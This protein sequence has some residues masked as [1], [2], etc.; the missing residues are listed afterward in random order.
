[1]FEKEIQRF[2]FYDKYS[3]FNHDLGRRET[4][5][6][7]VDRV[8]D[9]LIEL[10]G[11]KLSEESY[12]LI[13]NEILEGR[14]SPSMRLMATAGKAARRNPLLLYNCAYAPIADI[15]AFA[16]ILWLSMSGVGVGYS[17]EKQYTN[18]LP[19]IVE[20]IPSARIDDFLIDDS[21][22]GWVV[23][24]AMAVKTWFFGGDITFDY[25]EIRLEGTPL[26]TKGGTASGPGVLIDLMNRTREIILDAQGRKLKPI[27]VF[28]IVTT[29]GNCAVSGGVRRSAQLTMFDV[30]D[31]EMMTAKKGEFW[32]T[33]PYR[34][35]ANIS[36][37]WTNVRTR[38][39]IADQLNTMF[40]NQTGEPGIVSRL[41]MNLTKPERRRRLEHGGLNPC[42]PAFATVLTPEGIRTIGE[43]D[44]G[45]VIW[46]G[47]QWTRIVNKWST[48]V[49][50]VN[51]Y[52][53]T[54]GEFIG[55]SNHRVFSD[56][57]RVEAQYAQTMDACPAPY[58]AK[59]DFVSGKVTGV[60]YLGDFEVF[61]MTVDADEHSYWT[62]GLRVS[63]CAEIALHG[64]TVDGRMGGQLC[65]L[66]TVNVK[67]GMTRSEIET[68]AA[69]AAVIGTIQAMAT[70]FKLLRPTWTEICE[71]ERLVGVSMIGFSDNKLIREPKYMEMVKDLV[72]NTNR[73][74]A[75]ML[76]INPSPACTA[77]KP[78]GNSSVL[79]GTSRGINARYAPYYIRRV[80]VGTH[81]PVFK[82]MDISDFPM[83]P[84][85]GMHEMLEPPVH[86]ASFYEKSPNGAITM[87]DLSAID[88]LNLWRTIKE[89]WTEHNPSVTIEYRPE[90][91]S[92]IIEWTN[93]NQAI[94][95][96][97]AFL[98]TVDAVYEQPPYE[99]ISEAEYIVG[100]EKEPHIKWELLSRYEKTDQTQFDL[101]CA[102]GVCDLR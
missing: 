17:V 69:T 31:N 89:N 72:V 33:H 21:A 54:A 59:K 10:S 47:F 87:R 70:N 63:N 83:T 28:D 29:I 73:R 36:A 52:V 76:G 81:T 26:I 32:K 23:A 55:T 67:Y 91:E 44:V 86:V 65:N 93:R 25:S 12:D 101:E 68:A 77:V 14:V 1:M 50:P 22:E 30:D 102:G 2:V 24:Y 85:N 7:T 19:A 88:Q 60:E 97:V 75:I 8:V 56:G 4:W 5:K 38:G 39:E 40:T 46:S 79:Y 58:A 64:A 53:S 15:R 13:H 98:P 84:E 49:K 57:V 16:E 34:A 78:A 18:Q 71:E 48:G 9:F 11:N 95:N 92:A 27:E 61:D 37:V 42:Q 41:A 90:E 35:N 66:S 3:R 51:R 94:L 45:D 82:V 100:S 99:E 20:Q 62:G 6:E 96:G 74:T 43:V 80:R